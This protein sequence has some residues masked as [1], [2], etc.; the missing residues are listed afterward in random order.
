MDNIFN[1]IRNAGQSVINGIG[2]GI[3][4]GVG[5]VEN[6]ASNIGQGLNNTYQKYVA[7]PVQQ[8]TSALFNSLNSRAQELGGTVQGAVTGEAAS[9]PQMFQQYNPV[10]AILK[11]APTAENFGMNLVH[12]IGNTPYQPGNPASPTF[13]EL[14]NL[15]AD[16]TYR[17]FTRMGAQAVQTLQGSN[18]PY[19]PQGGLEQLL[20]GQQPLESYPLQSQQLSQFGQQ[21]LGMSPQAANIAA[22]ALVAADVC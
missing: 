2:Q 14:L 3:N 13:G 21:Q 7:Q 12:G 11:Y 19:Q 9:I 15:G 22:P 18:Q 1:T 5:D 4:T 6:F 8:D 16:F 10:Q 17:P 20:Y